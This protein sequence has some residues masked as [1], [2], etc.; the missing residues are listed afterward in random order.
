[1]FGWNESQEAYGQVCAN[2]HKG[3]LSDE[4][5]AGSASFAAMHELEKKL[6]H[7][8]QP[9]QHRMAKELLAGMCGAEIDKL[10]ETKGLDYMDTQKAKRQTKQ[11][12]EHLY[13]EQY[14]QYD[15]YEP[16]EQTPCKTLMNQFG[17]YEC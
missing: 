16:R 14:G 10:V 11:N 2:K 13:D 8:G 5:I 9:M 12:A 3:K 7:D 15:K 4:V 1:M 17:G 6:R